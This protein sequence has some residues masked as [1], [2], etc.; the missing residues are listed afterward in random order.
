MNAIKIGL[1]HDHG[2]WAPHIVPIG[3]DEGRYPPLIFLLVDTDLTAFAD[4]SDVIAAVVQRD[5][6]LCQ[7]SGGSDN[8]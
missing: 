4:P 2:Q 3:F 6:T 7:P 8:E 1:L 5:R